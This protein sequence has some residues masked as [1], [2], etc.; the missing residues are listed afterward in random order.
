[1]PFP[2]AAVLA[3]IQ[4]VTGAAKAAKGSSQQKNAQAEANRLFKLRKSYQTPAELYKMLNAAEYNAQTGYDPATLD[5]LT[6]QTDRA[7]DSA[8]DTAEVLGG[9]PNDLSG[10]FDSKM[11]QLIRIG[12]ENHALNMENFSKYL[13]AEEAIAKSKDAEYVS[14]QDLLKDQLQ[15][16]Q[17]NITAGAQEKTEGINTVI[18]AAADYAIG[19]L[20]DN[21]VDDSS[22]DDRQYKKFEKAY[23]DQASGAFDYAKKN[24]LNY[25]Q[26]KRRSNRMLK[27]LRTAIR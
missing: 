27:V 4:G 18:G 17:A 6:S 15:A 11:Q 8:L 7:F 12:A 14:E 25:S 1:M 16:A 23:G 10:L 3:V 22:S 26:Y 13:S 9:D 5:Y 20:Y 24:G 21:N 2:I 19:R